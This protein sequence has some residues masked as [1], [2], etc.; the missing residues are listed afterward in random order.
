MLALSDKA[1]SRI[2][3]AII[4]PTFTPY[5]DI[6]HA[7]REACESWRILSLLV[8]RSLDLTTAHQNLAANVNDALA[9][10]H[11][12]SVIQGA[13]APSMAMRSEIQPSSAARED[14]SDIRV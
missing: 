3:K 6:R 5:T 2:S 11:L 14:G 12:G 1:R 7:I 10:G 9:I 8:G 13:S 4:R